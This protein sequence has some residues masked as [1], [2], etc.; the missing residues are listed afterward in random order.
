MGPLLA[1]TLL[2]AAGCT[3]HGTPSGSS[4]ADFRPGA[5]G[6]GDP[7]FPGHGNGGYDVASYDLKV[8]YDPESDRLTGQATIVATATA[9]LSRFN[10]DFIGMTVD[11]VRV[12]AAP[13][14]SSRAG[15]EL[16]IR[17]A[18]GLPRGAR[19][20]MDIVY[21][22]VPGSANRP[23]NDGEGF[24]HTKD[25]ALAVG[26][27]LSASAWY[28]VN[29]H[30]QDK[31]T[32]TIAI[33]VPAGLSAL[34]N[35]VPEGASTQ[36]GWTT[37]RWAERTP[38][39]SYLTV[40]AI[41]DYRVKSGTHNGK[42]LVTA[43]SNEIPEG[44]VDRAM[45]RT[46]EIADYLATQFGPY[47]FDAYGGIVHNDSRV[48]FALETQSRP[49]YS[50]GFFAEGR[51]G[52]WV[53]AHELA[54][55]WFGDSVSV[56]QW[57]DIWLNEGFATY[58]EWLWAEHSR[59]D[60]VQEQFDRA[61]SRAPDS[62]WSTPPGDPGVARLFSPSV[63]DRGAM[64]LQALRRAVGD[65]AFFRIAKTWV[66]EKRNGNATTAEFIGLAERISGKPLRALFDAWLYQATKPPRP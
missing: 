38:M 39:A 63:Y 65:D 2:V 18:A 40:I 16:T 30:P 35:G 29:D 37:W 49:I 24:L 42:P 4:S 13:A 45:A 9:G 34:S 21:S 12:D 62:V 55:Q 54:H 15:N 41:G 10:L 26:Q 5:A 32:Y 36:D 22:G 7:Y 31:A 44:D 48:N 23:R 64:T 28:P 51:D 25:G 59:G 57:K 61:Y 20:T 19:F 8:R 52:V 58:A 50:P 17:P 53:V 1:G 66:A 46:G 43:I 11:S 60:S 3:G 56:H 27:P 47:P 6:L 33:T 14:T